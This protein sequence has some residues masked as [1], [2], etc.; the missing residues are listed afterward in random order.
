MISNHLTVAFRNIRKHR[1]FSLINII[2]LALSLTAFWI[3]AL[4]VADEL[5]YDRYHK[6]ADLIYRLASHAKWESGSFDITG[7]APPLSPTLKREFPEIAQ[8]V[9][10]DP[11]GG[12]VIRYQDQTFKEGN[13]LVTDSSFFNVFTHRFLAGDPHTA[14]LKPQS[15]VLTQSLAER[16]FGNTE[17]ALGK[18]IV[19]DNG[20]PEM[21]TAVV[22]NV[23]SNSHFTF[24]ALRRFDNTGTENW[25][26][27]HLYSYIMLKPGV[28]AAK[29]ESK[30]PRFLD[31]HAR[32]EMGNINYRIEL[33][34]LTSIHLHSHL[35]FELG[36]NGSTGYLYVL[37]FVALLILLIA[38]INYVN[39]TTA[40]ASIRLREIAVRK[41][42]GS[43][44]KKLL[45][46]LLTESFMI[47]A[48]ASVLSLVIVT[49]VTPFFSDLTG[50]DLNVRYFSPF[51]TAL[52][53]LGFVAFA[54]FS[55]GIYPALFLSA[56]SP[57][58]ALKGKAAKLPGRVVLRK[59]LVVF[60]FTVTVIMIAVSIIIF[61]QLDYVMNKDLG[62]NKNE[63]LTFHLDSKKVRANSG[64]LKE[65]LL[66]NPSVRAVATA[67]NPI[68]NN[69]IGM[70]VYQ[71]EKGGALDPHANIC[72]WMTIDEDFI[73]AM[74]IRIKEGRNFMKSMPTDSTGSVIINE[75]LM[76]KE[77]WKTA[78]G[79]KI[80]TGENEDGRPRIVTI[81]GVISDFN[82]YSLQH[83]IEPLVLQLP[84][85]ASDKDN[86]YVRLSNKDLKASLEYIES[87]FLEFDQENPF[88]YHFLDE[89]FA[90]QYATEQ[91]QGKL[92]LLFTGLTI[93]I[94]CLGLFGLITLSTEQRLK[95]IGIRKVLG[96]GTFTIV[97][98][99][100]A[101]LLKLILIAVMVAFPV[102]WWASD[103]WL[104]SF[105]YHAPVQWWIFMLSGALAMI[106]AV[107]TIGFQAV[108]TSARNPVESLKSE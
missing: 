105:A 69:N 6:H 62:F 59:S 95:E 11:E 67:G 75:A 94:A 102:S 32:S 3:I 86:V 64:A 108:K 41:V 49:L 45:S 44:R 46:M 60:Q 26:D 15:I 71:V 4:Y 39:I 74:Q 63:T 9:R 107:M 17:A 34:P 89:N 33:Q 76:R 29:L 24:K 88:E 98:L 18:T 12:G 7:T 56:F 36:N 66:Q 25:G 1:L 106:V 103:K 91:K 84:Q 47:I 27:L 5:S 72:Y 38:L 65:R 57:V 30:L 58:Q 53:V 79:R 96:A 97:K 77:G 92:L 35:G 52:F 83:K 16:L 14:L 37:S 61:R 2:G 10:I 80:Q 85:E 31:R 19:L 90:R 100:S 23:P 54:G 78:I 101:D 99:L 8:T 73:P 81:V 28:D 20:T 87:T 104:E 13:I 48:I 40:R 43:S 50:K 51:S 68:G 22:E 42:L 55:G 82:I 21:V 93:Y 70:G